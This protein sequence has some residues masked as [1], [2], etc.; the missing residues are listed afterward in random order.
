VRIEHAVIAKAPVFAG[1]LACSGAAAVTQR[2]GKISAVP[3][4][5]PGPISAVSVPMSLNWHGGGDATAFSTS[6]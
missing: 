3:A 5:T 4:W 1:I 2:C 6:L